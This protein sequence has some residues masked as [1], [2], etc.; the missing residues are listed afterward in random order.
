LQAK[1]SLREGKT[2]LT[3]ASYD[4]SNAKNSLWSASSYASQ[5]SWDT[6]DRDSS[7]AGYAAS[8]PYGSAQ[9]QTDDAARDARDGRSSAVR[10]NNTLRTGS[11]QLASLEQELRANGWAHAAELAGES[12]TAVTSAAS[13]ATNAADATNFLESKLSGV[14]TQLSFGQTYLYQIQWDRPGNDVSWA[15]RSLD[16]YIRSAQWDLNSASNHQSSASSDFTWAQMRAD[17]A[18]SKLDQLIRELE[19]LEGGGG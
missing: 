17:T 18:Q 12:H 10:A 3:N 8:V 4:I 6:R 5:A 15:A 7:W 13:S 1:D 9:W 2:S 19:R 14:R 16:S 11:K